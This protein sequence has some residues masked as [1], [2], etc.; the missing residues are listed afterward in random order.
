[1]PAFSLLYGTF[2]KY[3]LG[4]DTVC[5]DAE[6]LLIISGRHSRRLN[7]HPD[8]GRSAGFKKL[9]ELHAHIFEVRLPAKP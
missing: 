5:D 3:I 9:R 1:M 8:L 2:E 7:G 6:S 4:C